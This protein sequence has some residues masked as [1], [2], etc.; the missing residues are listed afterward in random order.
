MQDVVDITWW[1]I[2]LFATTLVIPFSINHY[3]K[4]GIGKDASVGLIR[5]TVQLALVGL[6]LEYLFYL[7]SL[8][9]N[10][11]WLA[12]MIL[13]GANA[14]AT[15]SKLPRKPIV[16]FVVVGLVIG[17]LPVLALLCLVTV[18]PDPFYS[19]QYAIP[20]SGMLLGNSLGGNIVALQNFYSTL[21]SRWSEYQA[22]ISLG[23]PIPMATLPFIRLSLQKSLAPILATMA[24]TGLVSLPGM[25]T[26]QILGGASP[27]VAIKYQLVIMMAIWVMMSISITVCLNLVVHRGFE[28]S[29]KPKIRPLDQS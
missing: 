6:Y 11:L 26:G 28:P 2:L 29:G 19:A 23:A 14:I 25:M 18:Q 20:L 16:G 3:Y 9:V 7:N 5:M 22:A 24:T 1:Q 12:V 17:L 8:V 10:L 4:L 15:K 13:V 27:V 21:E